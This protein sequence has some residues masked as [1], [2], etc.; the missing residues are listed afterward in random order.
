MGGDKTFRSCEKFEALEKRLN[1][2]QPK[3]TKGNCDTLATHKIM[4]GAN[5]GKQM[6]ACVCSDDMCNGPAKEE[7]LTSNTSTNG[8]VTVGFALVHL[9]FWSFILCLI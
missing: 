9:F 3:I 8:V 6:K 5:K 2:Y 4:D 7:N 1:S